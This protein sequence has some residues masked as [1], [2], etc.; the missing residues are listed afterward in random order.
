[1]GN[2]LQSLLHISATYLERVPGQNFVLFSI[3]RSISVLRAAILL[4]FVVRTELH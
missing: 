4:Q 3:F 2:S 1:M